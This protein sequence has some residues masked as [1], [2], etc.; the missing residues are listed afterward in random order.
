MPQESRRPQIPASLQDGAGQ[1]ISTLEAVSNDSSNSCHFGPGEG[2]GLLRLCLPHPPL[3]VRFYHL[4]SI[5][6]TP[7]PQLQS[8]EPCVQAWPWGGPIEWCSEG[9][10]FGHQVWGKGQ[11]SLGLCPFTCPASAETMGSAGSQQ[12][13][14]RQ[15]ATHSWAFPSGPSFQGKE[16]AWPPEV[17]AYPTADFPSRA[18]PPPASPAPTPWHPRPSL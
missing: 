7:L 2:P 14:R 5:F 10:H 18:L 4:I 12:A 16:G 11:A 6:P 1:P 8:S 3:S 17:A 15:K 9:T 13:E